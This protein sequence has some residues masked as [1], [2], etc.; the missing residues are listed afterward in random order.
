M[1]NHNNET[2]KKNI[3]SSEVLLAKL[4]DLE[5][6]I[7]ADLKSGFQDALG[8]PIPTAAEA[9][10]LKIDGA[11]KYTTELQID[12][13]LSG[14]LMLAMAAFTGAEA[15]IATKAVS[16]ATSAIKNIFGQSG[17]VSKFKGDAAKIDY[18]GEQY[19]AAVYASTQL[20]STKEWFTQKD[21]YVSKYCFTVFQRQ[22]AAA[23]SGPSG[24]PSKIDA[25]R[26]M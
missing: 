12:E 11:M 8:I 15:V 7:F 18:K 4:A 10:L 23:A 16:V 3:A 6:R 5:K 1:G 19:I 20:C 2:I 22:S 21:F 13:F 24:Q 26:E 25:L 9:E 17:M 14:A